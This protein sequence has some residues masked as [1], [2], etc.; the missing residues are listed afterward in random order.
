MHCLVVVVVVVVVVVSSNPCIEIKHCTEEAAVIKGSLIRGDDTGI[1]ASAT[2]AVVQGDD[3]VV[4]GDDDG[5]NDDDND[6]DHSI[7]HDTSLVLHGDMF[8]DCCTFAEMVVVMAV[9]GNGVEVF[10][11]NSHSDSVLTGEQ[12][13]H[14]SSAR[15]SMKFIESNP[16]KL[17]IN[18]CN[19]LTTKNS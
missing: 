13:S 14:S 16:M 18:E 4:H 9:T 5:D 19:L 12:S 17:E 7:P 1:E 10:V 2:V 11:S 3:I 6:D 15:L 8:D